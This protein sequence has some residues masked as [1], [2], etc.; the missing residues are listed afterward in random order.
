MQTRASCRWL[1]SFF[2]LAL[3]DGSDL[4]IFEA[5]TKLYKEPLCLSLCSSKLARQLVYFR[6]CSFPGCW[7]DLST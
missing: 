5:T 4:I 2:G 3:Q 6:L 7:G 1:C